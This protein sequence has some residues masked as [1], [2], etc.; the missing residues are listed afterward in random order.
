MKYFVTGG[1]GFLGRYLIR[2]VL[3][4]ASSSDE[5]HVLCRAERKFTDARIKCVV[6]DLTKLAEL[7]PLIQS[8][9][10]VF[11]I[12]GEARFGSH[13]DYFGSNV[14]PTRD[15]VSILKKCSVLKN[16]IFTSSIGAFD[17]HSSDRLKG[18]ITADCTAAPTSA[19][20]KSKLECERVI[21]DSGLP[22]T[23][24][25]PTWIWG[26]GM[27][28]DSHV[29]AF[30]SL[31]NKLPLMARFA[32][33]GKVS[34]VYVEDMARAMAATIE[35]PSVIGKCYFGVTETL[36][37]GDI[38]KRISHQLTGKGR[39]QIILPA[40]RPIF[41]RVHRRLPLA[42][43]NL[44][45]DYLTAEDSRFIEDFSLENPVRLS[46]GLNRVVE[47]NPNVS[48]VYVITGANSGI[49]LAVSRSLKEQ[50]KP[51]VLIDR[52]TSN[53]EEFSEHTIIQ[54]DLSDM[55]AL[56]RIVKSLESRPIRCLMNIAGVG[57]KGNFFEASSE[58]IDRTLAVNAHGTLMLTHQ[59]RHR[60]TA[61]RSDILNVASSVA[62]YPLPG[63][64]VYAASKAFLANWS[65]AL[66][67]EL[68]STNRVFT[69]SPGG[70]KTNF[71]RSAGVKE[72]TDLLSAEDVSA[73]ILKT[74]GR[75]PKTAIYG[76]R[77]KVMALTARILPPRT[78]ALLMGRLFREAR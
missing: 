53:L 59:L 74:I 36:P 48:G 70:T 39:S 20:G 64:A 28:L 46:E 51:L 62:Y 56:S 45:V 60:L 40:F 4:K 73:R 13:L 72:S 71:Q 33:P 2:E 15:L 3:S 41:G 58:S 10:Y 12:G 23:I 26:A 55:D 17:R 7:A 57:Y 27:R 78:V 30:V 11:H 66:A 43:A 16:L 14:V 49:G 9:E 6:G 65:E 38:L 31:V 44:F 68:R 77:A 42:L 37:I 8:C 50:G 21:V 61:D 5:I 54:A 67:V 52:E 1:T 69:I 18:P 32:F 34:L 19:Y 35:N 29:N 76:T 63:M 47:S 24:F 25:R 75:K 22:F